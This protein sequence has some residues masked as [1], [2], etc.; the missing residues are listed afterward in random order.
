MRDGCDDR[1]IDT[2]TRRRTTVT[3]ERQEK[4]PAKSESRERMNTVS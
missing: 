3:R 2:H 4:K 1:I